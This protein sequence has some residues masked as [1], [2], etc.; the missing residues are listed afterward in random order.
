MIPDG[1]TVDSLFELIYILYLSI[2]CS[3]VTIGTS[4]WRGILNA[5]LVVL[6]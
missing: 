3:G 6:Q 5:L 4:I 2:K 1:G